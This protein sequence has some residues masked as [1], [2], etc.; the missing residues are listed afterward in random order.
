MISL[1][2]TPDLQEVLK[3]NN[4]TPSEYL[5]AYSGES[6][7]LDLYTT[8]EIIVPGIAIYDSL[9]YKSL[10]SYECSVHER[11]L[12][13]TGLKVHIP[14]GYVGLVQE[15]G[16]VSKTPLKLRAG[17]IDAGYSGEIFINVVSVREDYT[18][19]K[20]TKT[21]FQ[22]IFVPV[23]TTFNVVD[24]NKFTELHSESQRRSGMIGSS[25][26]KMPNSK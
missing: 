6:A 22:I 20:G 23:C 14:P 19:S 18:L 9:T 3:Q 12:I 21:P 1:F 24:E 4:I 2:L 16:S 7:G 5:P 10:G 17:V 13:P 15:R 25:D 26:T 11:T 8:Q